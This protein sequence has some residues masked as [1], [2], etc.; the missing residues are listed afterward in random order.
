MARTG[1]A[2]NPG[3]RQI[4]RRPVRVTAPGP[5]GVL[6]LTDKHPPAG[7]LFTSQGMRIGVL[8]TCWLPT[9]ACVG[10]ISGGTPPPGDAASVAA[11]LDLSERSDY[12]EA[13]GEVPNPDRGF[14]GEYTGNALT[15]ARPLVAYRIDLGAFCDTSTLSPAFMAGLQDGF[16]RLL[17]ARKRAVVRF[18]YSRD[19]GLNPCGYFDATSL[20]IVRRHLS[21]LRPVL[22]KNVGAIAM[23]EMGFLGRWGEWHNFTTGPFEAAGAPGLVQSPA[24]RQV[25]VN[26]LLAAVPASRKLLMRYPLHRPQLA[27]SAAELSRIGFHNDCF[28]ASDTDEG[29]YPQ[30]TRDALQAQ[31][32]AYTRDAP[33]GGETCALGTNNRA[34]CAQALDE[35]ARL[36]TTYL[37]EEFFL[38]ALAAWQA[39]PEPCF[40]EIE[41][42][43]GY[44]YV[45]DGVRYAPGPLEAGG[46]AHVTLRLRNV[47]FAAMINERDVELVLVQ[48]ASVVPL[49]APASTLRDAHDARIWAPGQAVT[50]EVGG[51]VPAGLSGTWTYG[52]RLR[53][54]LAAGDEIPAG[55]DAVAFASTL[56][57]GTP[58][59]IPDLGVNSLGVTLTLP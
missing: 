43:L 3:T 26:Q 6:F 46:V 57:D 58:L 17:A 59:F 31:I 40:P 42:R 56:P 2:L 37:H 53:E 21:Q 41:R 25:M 33:M 38:P 11:F 27:N 36:H 51:L 14:L 7:L 50:V 15:V 32:A 4:R 5:T 8:L 28:L 13:P 49:Q 19:G 52:I 45:L 16:A 12:V 30:G 47:G 44:R 35:M 29:T 20:E 34:T 22:A 55:E 9:A 48:G 18:S 39:G 1:L 23:V 10:H 24:N 54:R